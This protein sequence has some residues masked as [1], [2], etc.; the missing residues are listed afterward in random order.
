MVAVVVGWAGV[1]VV[2]SAVVVSTEAHS[3]LRQECKSGTL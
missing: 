1:A 3:Y 2:A